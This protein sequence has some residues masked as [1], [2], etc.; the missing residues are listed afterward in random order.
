MT[1][2]S[3]VPRVITF[4]VRFWREWSAAGSRWRG[5]IKHVESGEAASFVDLDK[6]LQFLGWAGV[7]AEDESLPEEQEE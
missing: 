5:R 2:P 1:E 7:M 4:V 6:M 3:G